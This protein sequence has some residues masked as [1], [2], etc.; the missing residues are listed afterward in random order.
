MDGIARW[1][2]GIYVRLSKEDGKEVS[3]SIVYQIKR[4]ARYLRNFEDFI[5]FDI[6]IDDGKTG[7]DF[8]R[9]DYKRM[10]NDVISGNVNCIIIKDLTRYARNIADGI[11]ELDTF[12]LTHK[13]RFISLDR[14]KIDTLQD[15][16]AISSPE[17]YDALQ[18][19][20]KFASDTSKKVRETKEINREE[21]KKNGGFPV[22]GFLTNKDIDYWYIDE[23]ASKI[24]YQMFVWS[25]KDMSDGKI[26]KEL[27]SMGI[28][29]PAAYK[30]KKLGLKYYNPNVEN[31]K[32]LWAP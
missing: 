11:K 23:Y 32:G 8:D 6:Y 1:K 22:Y 28:L 10:Q 25:S 15:P 2:I 21:G 24:V 16:T 20:E 13:I 14:P 4:I 3:Q 29:N 31:N 7:T 9:K 26:A 27:N 5:V 12:V 18:S 30:R 19:A 17:V